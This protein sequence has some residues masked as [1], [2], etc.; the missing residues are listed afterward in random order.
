MAGAS[1]LGRVN[2]GAFVPSAGGAG[3]SAANDAIDNNS[4][5]AKAAMVF[6]LR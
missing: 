4:M 5:T 6:I 2:F 1:W 3:A